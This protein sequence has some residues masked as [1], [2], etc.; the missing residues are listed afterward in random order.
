MSCFSAFKQIAVDDDDVFYYNIQ[1]IRLR[2]PNGFIQTFE[3]KT[4]EN[5]GQH[6]VPVRLRQCV[7]INYR[8]VPDVI[9]L[10]AICLKNRL[11]HFTKQPN[12]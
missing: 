10:P 4:D 11:M 5:H 12:V 6:K 8:A 9:L 3:Q 1:I 2:S 7:V